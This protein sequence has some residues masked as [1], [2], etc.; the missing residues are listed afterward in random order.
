[1]N[2]AA[3]AE[4]DR[5]LSSALEH[6]HRRE[7]ARARGRSREVSVPKARSHPGSLGVPGGRASCG[8][9]GRSSEP[10]GASERD[11]ASQ[12]RVLSNRQIAPI[13]VETAHLLEGQ[14]ANP[15]R[16]RAYRNAAEA[17]ERLE[18]P[19][20]DI[21]RDEGRRGLEKVRGIGR[22]LARSIEQIALSGHFG[23]LDNLRG[24]ADP[25]CLFASVPGLGSEL[26]HRIHAEL[27]VETL[28]ELE[29]AAYDG[30]LAR[31]RGLGIV[32]LRRVRNALHEFLH[33]RHGVRTI[34]SDG[35]LHLEPEPPVSEILAVDRE[36]REKA[37]ANELPK[38]APRNLNP[39]HQAWLPILHTQRG[40]RHYTALYS[41]TERAHRL[42]KTSDWVVV[43]R[44]D[45]HG[46]GQWT[47]VTESRGKRAGKRVVR[48]REGERAS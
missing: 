48:G 15:F 20:V 25:E 16:V 47:V 10:T 12:R 6:L 30:R 19:V 22:S 44:D 4:I 18:R 41:N 32:R 45:D 7:A 3:K 40:D 29:A 35:L 38:I 28:P 17:I 42:G 24:H 11:A 37:A 1:M 26:A 21:L 34:G 39:D 9:R 33:P 14:K 2:A 23:L 46:H 5:A 43:Y 31:I 13:L 36:Y 8:G 27:G